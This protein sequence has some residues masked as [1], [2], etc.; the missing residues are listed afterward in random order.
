MSRPTF[1]PSTKMAIPAILVL[2]L[3]GCDEIDRVENPEC[4]YDTDCEIGSVCTVTECEPLK[5]PLILDPVCGADGRTYDN[6]CVATAFH[7]DVISADPCEGPSLP[8]LALAC[9]SNP[10]LCSAHPDLGDKSP[11]VVDLSRLCQVFP[12]RCRIQSTGE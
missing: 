4:V 3:A 6:W 5:C 8:D 10:E 12:E 7:V 1:L 2:I 9:D 11:P